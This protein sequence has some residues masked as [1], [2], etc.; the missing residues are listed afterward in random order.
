MERLKWVDRMTQAEWI[1]MGGVHIQ[2]GSGGRAG[3][4]TK[5]KCQA[6]GDGHHIVLQHSI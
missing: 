2:C 3:P 5:H 1:K 4:Q 6:A